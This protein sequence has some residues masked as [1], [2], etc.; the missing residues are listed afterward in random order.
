M[1]GLIFWGMIVCLAGAS[2]MDLLFTRSWLKE[3][4]EKLS[5]E[6][7]CTHQVVLL[8]L[9]SNHLKALALGAEKKLIPR[10][11]RVQLV[12]Y[13]ISAVCCVAWISL[14]LIRM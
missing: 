13:V 1:M 12:L 7:C 8:A 9:L 3:N 4:D 14:I 6:L 2:L 5:P 10:F 11:L